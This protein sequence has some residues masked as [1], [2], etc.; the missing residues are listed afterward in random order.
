MP[1]TMT[2]Q[3]PSAARALS[4]AARSDATSLLEIAQALCEIPC[5]ITVL[6]ELL[7]DRM[8]A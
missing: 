7:L 6:A 1:F 4:E 8:E 3:R 5:S 2:P